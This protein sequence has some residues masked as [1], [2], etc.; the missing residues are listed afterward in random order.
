MRE[1]GDHTKSTSLFLLPEDEHA[2]GLAIAERLPWAAWLCSQPG[3]NL[4]PV[5]LHPDVTSAMTCG[6]SQAFL[7]LPAGA[8]VEVAEDL[9][10]CLPAAQRPH[11]RAIVQLARSQILDRHPPRAMDSG[12]LAVKWNAEDV[13]PQANELLA[14]QVAAIWAGLRASTRPA[15]LVSME[16]GKPYSGQRV[17]EAARELILSEGLPV[18]FGSRWL[19]RLDP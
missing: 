13:G 2:L 12:W 15:H 3:L 17:G 8:G 11:R 14:A 16:T 6:G 19:F 10:P 1:R 18:T 9:A 7:P 4:H 5:H